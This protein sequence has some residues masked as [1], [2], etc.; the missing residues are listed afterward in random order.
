M[1]AVITN[2]KMLSP[3]ALSPKQQ[4]HAVPGNRKKAMNT[5]AM[6]IAAIQTIHF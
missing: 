2:R 6:E 1:C 4:L 3:V 5:I